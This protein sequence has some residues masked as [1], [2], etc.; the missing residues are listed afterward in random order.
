MVRTIIK[1]KNPP[2]ATMGIKTARASGPSA[3]R[4]RQPLALALLGKEPLS[5]IQP[6]AELV[7]LVAYLA[8]LLEDVLAPGLELPWRGLG[9]RTNPCRERPDHGEQQHETADD[10]DR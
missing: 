2:I 4:R 9:L 1:V 6:L 10:R 8:K 3:P 7:D 5:E